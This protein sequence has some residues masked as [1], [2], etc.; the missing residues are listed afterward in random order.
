MAAFHLAQL[1]IARMKHALD[2]PEMKDFVDNLD[3]INALAEQ[4]PGFVWRL[5]TEDGDATSVDFY[6]PDVLINMSVW[7]DVESLH[8][9][10]Y[11][12]AHAEVMSRRKQWFD[13]LRKA[14]TVL[15]W[16]PQGSLPTLQQANEKLQFLRQQGPGPEA[17]TFKK[18]YPPPDAGAGDSAQQIDDLCPAC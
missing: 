3:R 2:D 11:R 1:N 8:R 6:G 18:A 10:V 5:Q 17:F 7:A 9:Y 15:W 13:R 12:T 16:I 14:Y 4:A